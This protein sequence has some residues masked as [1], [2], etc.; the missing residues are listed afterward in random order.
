MKEGVSGE[1]FILMA[2]HSEQKASQLIIPVE[3]TGGVL[4]ELALELI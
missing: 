4:T 3:A 1:I 2:K